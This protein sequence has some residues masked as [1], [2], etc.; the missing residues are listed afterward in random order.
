MCT[1]ARLTDWHSGG[2][3]MRKPDSKEEGTPTVVVGSWYWPWTVPETICP[4]GWVM[5]NTPLPLCSY[6]S[7]HK[8]TPF[9]GYNP[10]FWCSCP[11]FIP[12]WLL[13]VISLAKP[14]LPVTRT[15][16]QYPPDFLFSLKW[17]FQTPSA[18]YLQVKYFCNFSILLY[19]Y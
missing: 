8:N 11:Y 14:A 9:L 10:D 6:H 5:F 12:L 3:C 4:C 16:V 13:D 15:S 2:P 18:P 7:A 19:F 1:H 17:V